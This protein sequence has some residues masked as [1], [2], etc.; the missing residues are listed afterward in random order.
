MKWKMKF[1]VGKCE[2][3]NMG[4]NNSNFIYTVMGSE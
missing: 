3:M 4:K 1:N 2:V